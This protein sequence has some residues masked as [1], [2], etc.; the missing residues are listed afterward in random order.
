MYD[1]ESLEEEIVLDRPLETTFLSSSFKSVS[2]LEQARPQIEEESDQPL[3]LSSSKSNA[4]LVNFPEEDGVEFSTKEEG[5]E[6]SDERDSNCSSNC[7]DS[8][9]SPLSERS[10]SPEVEKSPRR[11]QRLTRDEKWMMDHGVTEHI[12]IA[13]VIDKEHSELKQTVEGLVQAGNLDESQAREL[14]HIR[15]RGR[16]KITAKKSRKKK[17]AEIDHLKKAVRAAEKKQKPV[18]DEQRELLLQLAFWEE[19]FAELTHVILI[20]HGMHPDDYQ[21]VVD[22]DEVQ[23]VGREVVD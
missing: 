11:G 7:S 6:G 22:G 3:D 23:F 14:M 5:G 18:A 9:E 10:F 15:K 1:I 12:S 16:N 20:S 4:A 21:V 2:L 17:D 8:N 13:D 19:R